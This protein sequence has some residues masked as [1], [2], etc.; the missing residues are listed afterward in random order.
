MTTET[1]RDLAAI[2]RRYSAIHTGAVSDIL[3]G[4]GYRRQALPSAILPLSPEMRVAGPA[5]T[6]MG[7]VTSDVANN[8][9]PR[10]L[11]MLRAL[12]PLSVS[13]WT[14]MG[15]KDAAHWGELM[16]LAARNNGCTG[17]VID[18]GV[19]DSRLV[20][21]MGFPV[22][23]GFHAV[24]SSIG[25]WEIIACQ[26]PIEIGGVQIRPN[27]FV[28]GDIDGVVIVPAHCLLEV[29][30]KAEEL[31]EREAKMGA[32]LKAG[33]DIAECFKKYGAM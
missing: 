32:D 4:L 21:E 10:R 20:L 29:L 33:M 16:S 12:T 5:F 8:D 24:Q 31:R 15:H 17:A 27:D 6:G 13:V 7:R 19:R 2:C 3:D 22:F 28:V 1:A 26:I 14:T 18:G 11:E 30:E 25:R 9:M 23:A